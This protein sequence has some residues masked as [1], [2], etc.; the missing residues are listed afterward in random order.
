MQITN[1]KK[2]VCKSFERKGLGE[3]YDL[4]VQD[5]TLLLAD[6]IINFQNMHLEICELDTAHFLSVP[7]IKIKIKTQI[8]I[9]YINWYINWYIDYMLLYAEKVIRDRTGYATHQ[10]AKINNK[11]IKNCDEN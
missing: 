2:W 1:T 4:F 11:F 7:E 6:V 5:D 8:K 10:Y 3:H 9:R